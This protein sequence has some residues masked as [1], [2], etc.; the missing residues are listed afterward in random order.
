MTPPCF[1][2]RERQVWD[3]KGMGWVIDNIRQGKMKMRRGG[4]RVNDDW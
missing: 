2:G 4:K 1:K 3:K